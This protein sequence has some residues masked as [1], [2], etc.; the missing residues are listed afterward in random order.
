MFN[1]SISA[2]NVAAYIIFALYILMI[3]VV[4]IVCR[5]KSSSVNEFLFSK[6]GVGGWLTAFAYG[7]TYFSAVVFVG[8]A[9]KFGWS[10][11]LSAIWIGIGNTIFGTLI[12]WIVLAR[13]TKIMTNNIGAKTMP[14]FFEKRYDSK[15]IKLIASIV[16]FIFLI[17]YSSSV[18]QG[19]GYVFE[20]VF[21]LKSVW[22]ILILAVLTALYLFL[23]GYFATSITDFI[24]GCIMIIGIVTA[25]FVLLGNGNM[26]WGEGLK[27]IADSG[28]G[29]IPIAN[30][31]SGRFIDSP[32]FNVII[33][34][35][36][37]SF[38]IW[39]LPQSIH[40]F[41]AVKDNDAIKKGTII[42]TL[43]SLIV[44][45]GAYFMGSFVTKFV[46]AERFAQ[47]GSNTDMLVPEMITKNLPSALLG[48]IIVLLF[49]ASMSTLAAL[50][51]S[52]SSTVT[53][54]FVKGYVKPKLPEKNTNILLRCLCLVF[55]ALSAVLA[56][57]Q[58][59]AIVTLMSLSWGV[60]AGCFIGPYVFG[61]YFKKMNKAGAY[62]SIIASLVMTVILILALGYGLSPD[63]ISFGQAIKVGVGRSPLI[64]VVDMITSL[65]VTPVFSIIF[66]KKCAVSK[67]TLDKVFFEPKEINVEEMN[68]RV[69][70]EFD[71]YEAML[72]G[73]V[74]T[75]KIE[76]EAD[77][78]DIK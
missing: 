78:N 49:S 12:A 41:Y 65:I 19:L 4:S 71:S 5:R 44:G 26:N 50:S 17:P 70:E 21:G 68:G 3:I 63:G 32:L 31:A 8:Y 47:L 75:E 58:I 69:V 55:V 9:G 24:Q 7:A 28:K 1:F 57:V 53:M 33:I 35:L 2:T 42:S 52:S 34:T 74:K 48:L 46:S 29:L 6:K 14:D 64:G 36:L 20:S 56:I 25:V 43:F 77:I 15:H 73:R 22:C 54:D 45:G 62:A 16:I 30:S 18:Y 61:L 39:A 72:D 10:F 60:L 27:S 59:D 66:D 38:G 13:R 23:G 67:A 51:L 11:G 76:N 37:T 40:K